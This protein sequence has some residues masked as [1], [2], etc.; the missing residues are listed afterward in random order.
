MRKT[1]KIL[2]LFLSVVMLS[3]MFFGCAEKQVVKT[4]G[5]F[6]YWVTL[7]AATSQTLTSFDDMLMYQEISKITGT[8][9]KFIHPS[10][11]STGTEAF[12]ILLSSLILE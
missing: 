11:G 7:P 3:A 6:T 12:Q 1:T 8:N 10:A 5:E 4:G 9:V 2:S